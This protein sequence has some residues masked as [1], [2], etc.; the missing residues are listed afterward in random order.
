MLWNQFYQY[1]VIK[2]MTGFSLTLLVSS[3]KNMRKSPM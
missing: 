1:D 2:N 3:A